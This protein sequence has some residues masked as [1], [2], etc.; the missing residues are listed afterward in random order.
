M[1]TNTWRLVEPQLSDTYQLTLGDT[2]PSEASVKSKASFVRDES[3][4]TLPSDSLM[5]H[6]DSGIC[7]GL[8]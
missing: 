2:P 5:T 4:P 7:T 8:C 3:H 6:K 1:A